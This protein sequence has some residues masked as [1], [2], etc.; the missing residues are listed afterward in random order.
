MM[1]EAKS[2]EPILRVDSLSIVLPS[3]GDRTYAVEE[4]S[5]TVAAGEIV[6]IV[7]ES[8][9]GKSVTAF[10]V[11]GLLSPALRIA[12]GRVLF[13]GHDLLGSAAEENL[14]GVRGREVSII[15]QEPMTALNPMMSVGQQVAEV[16]VIHEPSLGAR[17]R[18]RRVVAMLD[19]VGLPDPAR[20]YSRFAH[21]ISGGQRQRVMIAMALILNPALLIADEPTTA[22]D[23]TTQAQILELI[24]RL[25]AERGTGVLFITHDIGVVRDIADR[26]VVM[27]HG[28][29]LETGSTQ[30]VLDS[31]QTDYSRLLIASVPS[32]ATDREM[33]TLPNRE[34]MLSVQ[35]LSKSFSTGYFRKRTTDALQQVDLSIA[36]GEVLSIV[37]ESGSGKSTLA[38][39]VAG[40]ETPT[41]GTITVDGV[42]IATSHAS[43]AKHRQ[44]V[45]MVFQ[46]PNRSLNPRRRIVDSLI[47]GP[48]NFGTPKR[49]AYRQAE[50]MVELVG[51]GPETLSRFPYQFSGGQRQRICIARALVMQPR[52]LIA[53]EAVSAL[54]VSVQKQILDLLETIRQRL[55][56]TIMFITHDLRVATQI[57]D[58]ICVMRLGR[59]V[60][61][62]TPNKIFSKPE[63]PY[64]RQ[65]MAAIPGVDLAKETNGAAW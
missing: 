6:C 24:K 17:E 47:E 59:I 63:D 8:G 29:V 42:V 60:E 45:Q 54:D 1:D 53:D 13:R 41:S 40:L 5:L 64:T 51:L 37:G 9:S 49:E 27:R 12:S 58:R 23:V 30:Q 2:A 34:T 48:V 39:C 65:L 7:G 16:L 19:A 62:G 26:V 44:L 10:A 18:K 11:L 56:L 21:Q 36:A 28:R 55:G 20:F 57:S 3:S 15:F 50:K 22:L 25:C 52:L 31:P 32:L 14:R 4:A 35:V 43:M 33:V 61:I 38:R 46:D